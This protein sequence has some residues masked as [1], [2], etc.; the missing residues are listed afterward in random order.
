MFSKLKLS[1][2]N[3]RCKKKWRRQNETTLIGRERRNTIR[4]TIRKSFECRR[5]RR[6]PNKLDVINFFQLY[7][8]DH[9]KL[10]QNEPKNSYSFI[11]GKR[12]IDNNS[13]RMCQYNNYRGSNGIFW[14]NIAIFKCCSEYSLMANRNKCCMFCRWSNMISEM[15]PLSIDDD[16]TAIALMYDDF[17]YF[18]PTNIFD[19]RVQST[20]NVGYYS[21]SPQK[22]QKSRYQWTK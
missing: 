18:E 1:Q 3:E 17:R 5:A 9:R 15:R 21:Y 4:L 14:N 20:I 10:S 11:K 2:R 12:T 22:A 6:R 16:K 8:Y 7:V 13:I 19:W